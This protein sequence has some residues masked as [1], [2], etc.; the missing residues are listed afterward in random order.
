MRF[1][2]RVLEALARHHLI[3]NREKCILRSS[4]DGLSPLHSNLD[5]IPHRY[6]PSSSRTLPGPTD[7]QALTVVLVTSGSGHRPERLQA[8]TQFTPCRENIDAHMLSKATPD[9][10]SDSV[11]DPFEPDLVLMLHTP[12][13]EVASGRNNQL[14]V[15]IREG[16]PSKVLE[17]LV[18]FHHVRGDL[19]CFNDVCVARGLCTVLQHIESMH[20]QHAEGHLGVVNTKQRW[21]GVVWWPGI[22]KDVTTI[23]KDCAA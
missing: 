8:T 15:F 4:A 11:Q 20:P 7:Q 2:F 22:D 23:V 13:L 17:D 3:L 21:M 12:Q 18:T 16:W 1:N 19:S 14:C 10:E 6:V 9:S 5:A